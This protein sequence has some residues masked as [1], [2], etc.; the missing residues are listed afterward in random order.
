MFFGVLYFLLSGVVRLLFRIKVIGRENEPDEDG[1]VVCANHIA[2][3][4]PIMICYAF[5]KH[6]IR[7]MAKKE[8]FN[9]PFLNKL[10]T[11]LGAYPVNRGGVDVSAIKNSINIVKGGRCVGIFPQGHREKGKTPMEADL[12]NGAAMIVTKSNATI[13][14]CCIVTKKNRFSFFRRVDVYYGKPIKFEELNYDHENPGE[15]TRITELMFDRVRQMYK[16]A[17]GA[18][19]TKSAE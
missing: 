5:K 12:K 19:E 13:L 15:Y 6:Q 7:Y 11:A 8:L 3:T 9:V 16:N 14:P 18:E 4:D 2:A 17:T 10:V 1:F